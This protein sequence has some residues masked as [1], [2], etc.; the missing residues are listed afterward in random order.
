VA[1]FE[2]C[3]ACFFFHPF[4]PTT[5]LFSPKN[6][7]VTERHG[8][9]EIDSASLFCTSLV[10]T[11]TDQIPQPQYMHDVSIPVVSKLDSSLVTSNLQFVFFL[12]YEVDVALD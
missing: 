9:Y 4:T 2:T 8:V 3:A 11:R 6:S 1:T 7:I 5:N 10:T 12:H